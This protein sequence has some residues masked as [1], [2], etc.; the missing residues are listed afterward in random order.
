[1]Q[2]LNEIKNHIIL[3]LKDKVPML[4]DKILTGDEH[5]DSRELY[6]DSIEIIELFIELE[7]KYNVE[8]FDFATLNGDITINALCEAIAEK[9]NDEN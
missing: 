4:K 7:D 1:M 5:I 2:I 8:I 3:Y 9:I 6:F